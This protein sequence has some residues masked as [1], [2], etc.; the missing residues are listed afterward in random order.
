MNDFLVHIKVFDQKKIHDVW[1]GQNSII[2]DFIADIEHSWFQGNFN[3][4]HFCYH[5]EGERILAGNHSWL[6]NDVLPG[7][8]FILF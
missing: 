1:V 5:V 6:D 8:H 3:Y 2:R 7:D 4:E